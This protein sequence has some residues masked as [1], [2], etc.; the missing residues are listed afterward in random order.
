METRKWM[1]KLAFALA[2]SLGVCGT[3]SA[4]SL[5]EAA[6]PYQGTTINI[7]GL[8]RPSYKAAQ[9]LTPRFEKLTGI[10]VNWTTLPYE[11]ALK[12]QTL[13]FVSR[14]DQYDVV[15]SDVIWPMAFIGA[16]WVV[17]I[18]HFTSNPKL[19]DPALDLA[20]FFPISLA[21]YTVNDKLYGLPFN[22]NAGL[23]FYNKK[24]LKQAGFDGPPKTWSEL[25]KY[26]KK[27]T[28]KENG[29]YGYVLQSAHNETQTADAFA[30]FLWPWGG[31][32]L[33]IEN[34]KV[35]VN[36]PQSVDGLKFRRKLVKLMPSS[37][38][39]DD[40]PQVVQMLIQG[41]AAMITEWASFYSTL[42]Q[43]RI[44]DQLGVALEPRGPKGR[45]SAFG[46]FAYM[47]S[48]QSPTKKQNAAYLF[49]QWLTSK[50][51]TRPL[52]DE[53]A[54]VS[55]QSAD[56]DPKIQA[57]YP[58]LKPMVEEW[59]HG[60]VPAY[61]PQIQCYPKFSDLVSDWGSRMEQRQLP[62]K[63]TLDKL[64]SELQD[65]MDSSDCWS[66]ANTP[67]DYMKKYRDMQK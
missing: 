42:K 63:P 51:M 12:A 28:D 34:K 48:A 4:W 8:E 26:S 58:Y 27:L 60:T 67:R 1:P 59:E 9:K 65:Y 5:K 49:I 44:G 64:A 20:D 11:S 13:N 25:L 37:I 3:A 33:D 31:R 23:L 50:E 14:S 24:M 10:H 15:L 46:D 38:V 2:A 56:K 22:G 35:M 61:R 18:Q 19:K 57:Q 36:S 30:R 43:S 32:F 53:G 40:H 29:Q 62:V 7:I 45:V 16:G 47:V 39:S 41:K 66:H 54:V 55:R 21:T 17:P 6:K 52:I